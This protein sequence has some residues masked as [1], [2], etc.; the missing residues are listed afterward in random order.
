M[1]LFVIAGLCLL[2]VPLAGGRIGR[3]ADVRLH[4]IW[5]SPLALGLQLVIVTLAPGGNRP[6][7]AAIHIATYVLIGAF[8]WANRRLPGVAVIAIGASMNALAIV[9]N[10]GV[11]PAVASAQRIAGSTAG[12]GFNNSAHVA[13]PYLAWLGDVIPVP[14]PLPNV[15]SIGDVIVFAGLLVLL[16]RT[17]GDVRSHSASEPQGREPRVSGPR[18]SRSDLAG[19]TDP[20]CRG[21]RASPVLLPARR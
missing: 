8:L 14:G 13:H 6:V 4:A 20:P 3:L 16:H 17:C 15:I 2:T 19:E 12:S 18:A 11:M 7:H 9:L 5:L 10:R 21:S 1:I